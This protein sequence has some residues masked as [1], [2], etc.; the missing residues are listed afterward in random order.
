MRSVLLV[1]AV[2]LFGAACGDRAGGPD[3]SGPFVIPCPT[4]IPTSVDFGEVESGTTVRRDIGL[5]SKGNPTF[6][7]SVDLPFTVSFSQVVNFRQLN[8][9]FTPMDGRA[10]VATLRMAPAPDCAEVDIAL[11]GSGTGRLAVSRTEVDF[12]EL[13]TGET[14]ERQ[15]IVSN[16]RRVALDVTATVRGGSWV[17]AQPPRTFT[18]QPGASQMLTL[19]ATFAFGDQLATLDLRAALDSLAVPLRMKGLAP[20]VVFFTFQQPN[21]TLLVPNFGAPDFVQRQIGVRNA[22]TLNLS[23]SAMDVSPVGATLVPPIPTLIGPD[24]LV[25]VGMRFLTNLPDGF[26]DFRVSLSSNDPVNPAAGL[27]FRVE[28]RTMTE[29][30]SLSFPPS[31]A[32]VGDGGASVM[33]TNTSANPCL[34]DDIHGDGFMGEG[35]QVLLQPQ[36]STFVGVTGLTRLRF[37]PMRVGSTYEEIVVTR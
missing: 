26:Y 7:S 24:T 23:V 11:T 20:R 34:L 1:A 10:Y 15:I 25:P 12:G 21:T 30:G 22:G 9:S 2:A 3:A 37:R 31:V 29:C 6:L 35:F 28:S 33:I 5:S 18:L 14:S 8:L 19:N 16:T 13:R 36:S 4:D 32:G 17:T 27:T